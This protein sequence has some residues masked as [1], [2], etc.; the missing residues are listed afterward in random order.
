MPAQPLDRRRGQRSQSMVEFA[1]IAP[2]MVSLYLGCVEISDGV[3]AQRKVTLIAST[4]ANLAAQ[5]TTLSTTDVSNIL[6][7]STAIIYPY[8]SSTLKMTVSCIAIDANKNATVKWS[9]TRNGTALSGSVTLPTALQVA[10]SQ[11]VYSQVS[12]GYRPAVGYTITGTLT[13]SEQMY[14]MPRITA[15]TYNTTACT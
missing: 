5:S 7:A 13:L 4:V 1:L 3:S 14:M 9:V 10:N 15:P 11:L 12:Y 2:L 8:S 6:D